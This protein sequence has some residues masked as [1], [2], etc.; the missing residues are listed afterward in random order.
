MRGRSA[1]RLLAKC[2]GG[3]QQSYVCEPF[4]TATVH[5]FHSSQTGSYPIVYNLGNCASAQFYPESL[6][7]GYIQDLFLPLSSRI[8]SEKTGAVYGHSGE[9]LINQHNPYRVKSLPTLRFSSADLDKWKFRRTHPPFSPPQLNSAAAHPPEIENPLDPP[10][11][12]VGPGIANYHAYYTVK[13][14]TSC[15]A[16]YSNYLNWC[17]TDEGVTDMTTDGEPNCPKDSLGFSYPAKHIWTN[18]DVPQPF[19]ATDWWEDS[20]ATPVTTWL[21]T[22]KGL[23]PFCTPITAY[24][25]SGTPLGQY[26]GLCHMI[27]FNNNFYVGANDQG[28]QTAADP[29][30]LPIDWTSSEN[31]QPPVK[32]WKDAHSVD[33]HIYMV[34]SPAS[35]GSLKSPRICSKR[36]WRPNNT[37]GNTWNPQIRGI[38][39]PDK[40][41]FLCGSPRGDWGA[42]LKLKIL[43]SNET[44]ERVISMGNF[45]AYLVP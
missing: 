9:N 38:C 30:N 3:S 42:R 31:P 40:T 14:R 33:V 17:F 43:N 39:F 37:I 2:G 27:F 29:G 18:A 36:F 13:R 10:M 16:Q 44:V 11:Y 8:G 34:A 26:I 35:P 12:A 7:S 25:S 15:D 22:G 19:Q 32:R 21:P 5:V 4:K 20:G 23:I 6:E 45:A 41:Y 28:A 24:N 1:H